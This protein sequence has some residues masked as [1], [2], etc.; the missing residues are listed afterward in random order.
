[1]IGG[2]MTYYSELLTESREIATTRMTEEAE[3]MG[4]D[5]IINVR[6]LTSM[7]MASA[8]EVLA[9]GTAVKIK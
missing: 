8:S 4:A 3:K 9:Y 6:Y 5:A 1:M 7:V 2:E